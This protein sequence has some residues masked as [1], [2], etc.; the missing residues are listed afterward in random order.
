MICF[1]NRPVY[2]MKGCNHTICTLCA[3]RMKDMPSNI[4]YPFSNIFTVKCQG[5]R[6]L[7]CPYCRTREPVQFRQILSYKEFKD[8][9]CNYVCTHMKECGLWTPSTLDD[10]KRTH[11]A[12]IKTAYKAYKLNFHNNIKKEY[13]LWMQLELSYDG[14]KSIIN[15]MYN[16]YYNGKNRPYMITWTVYGREGPISIH[17]F[18]MEPPYKYQKHIDGSPLRPQKVILNKRICTQLRRNR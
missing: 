14:E 1:E 5:V 3:D 18:D 9:C 2:K 13:D 17:E 15:M 16:D 10:Y 6:C 7:R 12:Y 4:V 11:D 8:S